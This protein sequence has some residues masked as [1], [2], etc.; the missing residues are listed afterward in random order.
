[1]RWDRNHESEDVI[2]RRGEGGPAGAGVGG[3]GILFWLFSRFGFKGLLIGGVVLAVGYFMSASPGTDSSSGDGRTSSAEDRSNQRGVA[4]GQEPAAADDPARFVGFVLDDVQKTWAEIF[5]KNGAQYSR[6]K[7]VLFSGATASG[8]GTGTTQT[9]PFYCPRD[10]RVY[11]DLDFYRELA[12]RFGAPGDFAQAYVIAHEVG[13][14]VQNLLGTMERAR[15]LAQGT[16]HENEASIR[17]EL[18]ADCYAGVWAHSTQQRDLLQAGDVEEGLRAAAA[19]GD[20]ALQRQAQGRVSPESW[21]HGSS[22][23]RVTWFKRG[24]ETGS[25][26][27]C[28]TERGVP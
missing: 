19:V 26:N 28:D 1:M 20:D 5:A 8:C 9:G 3:A 13:H 10:R 7:L 21:T 15:Q 24:Y 25:T 27:A 12:R 17:Q 4:P 18:Q 6:A 14:H 16:D 11:I 23:Q 2:D 22:A